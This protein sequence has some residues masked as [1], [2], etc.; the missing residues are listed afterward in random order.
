MIYFGVYWLILI[1]FLFVY[2][3]S[4]IEKFKN[5][6][7]SVDDVGIL[8][9]IFLSSL[10]LISIITK[11]PLQILG[12]EIPMELQWLASLLISGFGAWKFYLNPLK[13]KVYDMDREVGEVK[14]SVNNVEKNVNIIL[15]KCLTEKKKNKN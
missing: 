6:R 7:K 1:I 13:K 15:D 5:L 11:D 12:I 8:V 3:I 10:L 4:R 9:F 2:I 14:T